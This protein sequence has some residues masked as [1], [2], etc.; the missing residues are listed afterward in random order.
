[1]TPE[2]AKALLPVITAYAEGRNVEYYSTVS[3][4][5]NPVDEADFSDPPER[6]RIRPT[7]VFRVE[8]ALGTLVPTQFANLESAQEYA[9]RFCN[10]WFRIYQQIDL[11]ST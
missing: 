11:T 8:R 2:N 5:W 3:N 6:Y 1:M 4:K 7:P 9:N 10:G